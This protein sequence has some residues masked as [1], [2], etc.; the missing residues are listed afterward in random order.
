MS[1]IIDT[2]DKIIGNNRE[3]KRLR[4]EN[5][6]LRDELVASCSH[7]SVVKSGCRFETLALNFQPEK[8]ICSVCGLE[9]KA[10]DK[11]TDAL[12]D[13]SSVVKIVSWD[14]LFK[15]RELRPLK[16]VLVPEDK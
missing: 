12:W 16:A 15:Y 2:R 9:E 3:I 14:E 10:D 7:S 5:K 8:V 6:I 11:K 4:G 13:E 1:G